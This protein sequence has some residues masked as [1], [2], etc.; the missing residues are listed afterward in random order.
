MNEQKLKQ[1][2]HDYWNEQSCG[3]EHTKERK[4]TLSYFEDIEEFRYRIEPEI[5]SFAQFTRFHGKKVLEV[6]VGAGTDF[7]QWARAGA[8]AH[9][10]DLTQEA[11]DNTQKRLALQGLKAAQLQRA[12]AENIPY[13]DNY[14]DL[15]YS[16]GVIHHSPDTPRCLAELVRVCKPGGTIKLML[17]HRYSLFAFY[18]WIL[19][20]LRKGK[21]WR[22]LTDVIFH[23][24]ESPGTKAYS[25]AEVQKMVA[26]HSVTVQHLSAPA[27]AH[28]LL[29]YKSKSVQRLASL[30]ANIRGRTCSGWYMLIELKKN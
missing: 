2:V 19:A 14:F 15:V 29:Y 8:E 20:A 10:I 11:I 5:F 4:H 28:D 3:T 7:V 24:Q 18:R 9:G 12:D 21:P 16:W 27:T 25:F 6:G 17:Y 30:A 23:D 13:A 22:S 26:Q 1:H